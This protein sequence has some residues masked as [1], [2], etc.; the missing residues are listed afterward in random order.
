MKLLIKDILSP[1]E[2]KKLIEEC[3]PFLRGINL[4]TV[5]G[6]PGFQSD[7]VQ[8]DG[9]GYAQ[10]ENIHKKFLNIAQREL[11]KRLNWDITWFLYTK[12]RIEN[13]TW[14]THPVDYAGVYYM[15]TTPFFNNGTEFKDGFFRAPQNSL[16]IFSG[17]LQHRAPSSIFPLER[18]TMALNWNKHPNREEVR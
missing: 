14:H 11:N 12:G 13:N 3:K 8:R 7:P 10:F 17:H 2:R 6:R 15:K 16:L 9:E 4:D 18:Y 1:K 5:D